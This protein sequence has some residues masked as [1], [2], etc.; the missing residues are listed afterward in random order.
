MG[1]QYAYTAFN[2]QFETP[3][4]TDPSTFNHAYHDALAIPLT[5]YDFYLGNNVDGTMGVLNWLDAGLNDAAH[6]RY[7]YIDSNARVAL[8]NTHY[9]RFQHGRGTATPEDLNLAWDS[10]YALFQKLY[11]ASECIVYNWTPSN[12]YRKTMMKN[13]PGVRKD[14]L[15]SC[16]HPLVEGEI[17]K[18][19]V[20]A[21][22]NPAVDLTTVSWVEQQ[23]WIPR[24]KDNYVDIRDCGEKQA[25]AQWPMLPKESDV[26]WIQLFTT[27][28]EDDPGTMV[29]VVR[30]YD[31]EFSM[32]NPGV[33]DT[34]AAFLRSQPQHRP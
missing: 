34:Y 4:P 33:S 18:V 3:L 17:I 12:G 29:S 24:S 22:G 31:E 21:W 10:A 23:C 32:A 16:P 1:F 19:S 8:P 28:S 13:E 2:Y 11:P 27:A 9:Y 30:L 5:A 20:S 26:T 25:N 7:H 14:I 6:Y 15:Y